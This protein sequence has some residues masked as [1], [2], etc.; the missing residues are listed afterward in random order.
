MPYIRYC[1]CCEASVVDRADSSGVD[2]VRRFTYTM[3]HLPLDRQTD[4]L[5][6]R[7]WMYLRG[8]L[9]IY[10]SLFSRIIREESKKNYPNK[11]NSCGKAPAIGLHCRHSRELQ[12]EEG[13]GNWYLFGLAIPDCSITPGRRRLFR[14][15]S[16]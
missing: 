15:E 11:F 8:K 10:E 12:L 3:R 6:R 16:S 1:I 13:L 2:D 14:L 4:W 7:A 5:N 9:S